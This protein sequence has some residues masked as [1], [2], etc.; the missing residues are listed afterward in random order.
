MSLLVPT[1]SLLSLAPLPC[2]LFLK[3]PSAIASD[4]SKSPLSLIVNSNN[5]AFPVVGLAIAILLLFIIVLPKTFPASYPASLP[6]DNALN[7]ANDS[8]SVLVFI[9]TSVKANILPNVVSEKLLNIS[10]IALLVLLT[11]Y[12]SP[13]LVTRMFLSNII[14]SAKSSY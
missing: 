12:N 10:L 8:F 5:L 3:T 4:I 1:I 7:I 14:S 9:L 11:S 13:L 6:V 2:I